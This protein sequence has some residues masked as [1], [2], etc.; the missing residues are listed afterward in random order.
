MTLNNLR[1]SKL[2]L[3]LKIDDHRKKFFTY[4]IIVFIYNFLLDNKY[5]FGYILY[6][7]QFSLNLKID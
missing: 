7:M 1:S 5:N 4:F 3:E 6:I 2:K